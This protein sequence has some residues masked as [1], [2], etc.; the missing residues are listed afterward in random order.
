M[1]VRWEYRHAFGERNGRLGTGGDVV[2]GPGVGELL[3]GGRTQDGGTGRVLGT[4]RSAPK[5]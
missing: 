2:G 4:S 3:E 1:Y 5:Q